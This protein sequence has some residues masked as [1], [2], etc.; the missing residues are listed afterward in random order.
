MWYSCNWLISRLICDK[1]TMQR[2]EVSK[3]LRVTDWINCGLCNGWVHIK[4]ANLSRTEARNLVKFKCSRCSLVNTIPQCQDV[5]RKRI[6]KSSQIPLAENLIPKYNDICET[7]SNFALRCFLLS[8]ISCSLEKPPRG[9][10]RQK[11]SLS[12]NINKRIRDGVFEKKPKR[13]RKP[14]QKSKL[15]RRLRSI[16]TKLDEGN[17]KAGKDR[18]RNF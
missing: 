11:S 10:K 5:R 6:P 2:S 12:A 7:T 4:C 3:D 9:G 13:G 8:S 14:Q 17:V 15:G 16:C 18:S 1:I